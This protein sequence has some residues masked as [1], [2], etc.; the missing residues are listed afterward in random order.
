M[1]NKSDQPMDLSQILRMAQSPAGQQLIRMLQQQDG[2]RLRTAKQQA[3]QG[4]YTLAQ[5]TI[6]E[7]L[8]NPQAQKLLKQMEES[9]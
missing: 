4:D 2:D 5:K 8:K 7:F 3:S 1:Q 9:K 6:S